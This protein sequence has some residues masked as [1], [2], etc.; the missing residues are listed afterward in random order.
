MKVVDA[1]PLYCLSVELVE[2]LEPTQSFPVP[3]VSWLF[4]R[5][6]VAHMDERGREMETRVRTFEPNS[7]TSVKYWEMEK[8]AKSKC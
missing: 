1:A 8:M 5:A 3:M 6:A 4:S 2:A 7:E